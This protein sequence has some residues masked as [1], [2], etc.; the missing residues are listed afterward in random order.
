MGYETAY[1]NPTYR[2]PSF[3]LKMKADDLN[4]RDYEER[5]DSLD[6]QTLLR[7]HD[8]YVELSNMGSYG[9]SDG[10]GYAG[11]TITAGMLP[12]VEITVSAE[13]DWSVIRSYLVETSGAYAGKI[14]TG[15]GNWRGLR[16][17]GRMGAGMAA[18][19]GISTL[20]EALNLYE[21][22]G[23]ASYMIRWVVVLAV[24]GGVS[25]LL[26]RKVGASSMKNRKIVA[27]CNLL[28]A[29]SEIK[30]GSGYG[31]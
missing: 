8:K 18:G 23:S 21:Y 24:W 10:G 26:S 4:Q 28:A 22:L 30:T 5:I 31:F 19:F 3:T 7:I 25:A 12:K 14:R 15:G 9:T 29:G 13:N 1:Q 6:E 27:T 17:V 20:L 16:R 11:A 2:V